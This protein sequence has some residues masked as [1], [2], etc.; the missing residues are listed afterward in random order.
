M[1]NVLYSHQ[2]QCFTFANKGPECLPVF[3]SPSKISSQTANASHSG[4][5]QEN[6]TLGQPYSGK[7]GRCRSAE[8]RG[9]VELHQYQLILESQSQ[10]APWPN[11]ARPTK[12]TYLSQSHQ[13]LNS[14]HHVASGKQP[15]TKNGHSHPRYKNQL[16]PHF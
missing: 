16:P 12:I 11:P 13:L 6:R 5:I 1:R 8:P 2:N 9:E 3:P 4:L 7:Q 14:A 15:N 10:A